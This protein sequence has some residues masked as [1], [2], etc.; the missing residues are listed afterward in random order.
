MK[1]I[2]HVII[3]NPIDT[4]RGMMVRFTSPATRGFLSLHL[5]L[6]PLFVTKENLWDQGRPTLGRADKS[7]ILREGD[8]NNSIHSS[9]S[10]EWLFCLLDSKLLVH[11]YSS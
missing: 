6:S 5:F 1:T 10:T 3:I 7:H 11:P 9:I 8:N 4:Y 2:G